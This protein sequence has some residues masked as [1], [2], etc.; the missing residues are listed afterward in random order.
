MEYHMEDWMEDQME[1]HMEDRMECWIRYCINAATA[2][3]IFMLHLG[4]ING[5]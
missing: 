2:N 3:A 5:V 1:Y 4:M